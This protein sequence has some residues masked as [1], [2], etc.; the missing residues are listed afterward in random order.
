MVTN[1][2]QPQ[3]HNNTLLGYWAAHEQYSMQDLLGFVLKLRKAALQL[4]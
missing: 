2:E 4:L 1:R 3:A